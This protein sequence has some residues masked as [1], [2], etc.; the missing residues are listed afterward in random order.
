MTRFIIQNLDNDAIDADYRD[1]III[2]ASELGDVPIFEI[3][4]EKR[5]NIMGQNGSSIF[6]AVTY[7]HV[8]LLRFLLKK[9][10]RSPMPFQ[11]A[12]FV[13]ISVTIANHFLLGFTLVTSFISMVCEIY[14]R[15]RHMSGSFQIFGIMQD[16]SFCYNSK[17][18]YGMY[19]FSLTAA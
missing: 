7:G 10:R 17:Q 16:N 8:K 3:L 9:R 15:T 1:L 2:R 18:D 4:D 19:L 11:T 12:H 5:W 14:C 6:T 13:F